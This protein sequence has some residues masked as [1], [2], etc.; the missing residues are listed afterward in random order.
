MCTLSFGIRSRFIFPTL[1]RK[2]YFLNIIMAQTLIELYR[3][4][5]KYV[6]TVRRLAS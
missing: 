2:K 3:P 1:S 5:T 6:Q 4:K